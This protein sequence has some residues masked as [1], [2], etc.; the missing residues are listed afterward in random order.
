MCFFNY[1]KKIYKNVVM[2][3]QKSVDTFK[4]CKGM[5]SLL[6]SFRVKEHT[7]NVTKT[8]LFTVQLESA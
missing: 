3:F 4:H 5:L 2:H 7:P 6:Q 1:K 8:A